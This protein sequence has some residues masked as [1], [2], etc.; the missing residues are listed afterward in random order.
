MGGVSFLFLLL[1]PF[2]SYTGKSTKL[3]LPATPVLRSVRPSTRA[4]DDLHCAAQSLSLSG[5]AARI[6]NHAFHPIHRHEIRSN[7]PCPESSRPT[8]GVLFTPRV[9]RALRSSRIAPCLASRVSPAHSNILSLALQL[10][11]YLHLWRNASV[12]PTIRRCAACTAS[13]C[14]WRWVFRFYTRSTFCLQ[15][16]RC[17][18]T[19]SILLLSILFWSHIFFCFMIRDG[20]ER[21]KTM[22]PTASG[23]LLLLFITAADLLQHGGAITSTSSCGITTST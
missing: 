22:S 6:F 15:Q 4:C 18:F 19:R 8:A 9:F 11:C 13:L 14:V 1:L 17:V 21:S 7:L 10:R 12:V 16:A 5:L 3:R 23:T 2:H 20:Y